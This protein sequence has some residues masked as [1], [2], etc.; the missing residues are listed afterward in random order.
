MNGPARKIGI[1]EGDVFLILFEC[2]WGPLVSVR[3][4]SVELPLPH[5]LKAYS[6]EDTVSLS[7]FRGHLL[8]TLNRGGDEKIS[9]NRKRISELTRIPSRG[10][11]L[12]SFYLF[13]PV[14]SLPVNFF[15]FLQSSSKVA[16]VTE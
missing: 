1:E 6:E 7:I 11:I 9:P 4:R 15:P 16:S 5:R 3:F 12:L 8:E 13:S 14:H 10:R 2:L